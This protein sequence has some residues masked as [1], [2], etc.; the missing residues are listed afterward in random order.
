MICPLPLAS[1]DDFVPHGDKYALK[2]KNF[3]LLPGCIADSPENGAKQYNE[4]LVRHI[5]VANKI[6]NHKI[7]TRFANNRRVRKIQ[8]LFLNNSGRVSDLSN[9]ERVIMFMLIIETDN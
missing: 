6:R 3:L 8:Q 4:N 2:G 1:I 9:I 7:S 5:G